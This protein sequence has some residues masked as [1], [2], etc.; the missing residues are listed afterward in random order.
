MDNF[1]I[2]DALEACG[3]ELRGSA[4]LKAGLREIVIDSRLIKPGD[5][6]VAYRGEKVDGHDY[7]SAALDRGAACCLAERVP[8]GEGR[9]LILVPDVQSALEKIA[10]AY[11][12]RFSIPLIGV[13]GSVG[14]T[15]TKEMLH[16]VLSRRFNTLKTEGNLN[17]QIGVPMTLSRL[18]GRHEAAV[19][20]LGISG[21]GEMSVLA[22]MARPNIAVFTRIAHAHLE[23]LHD[24]DGVF[25]AKTELL[26]YLPP[27]GLVIV[28]GDDEKLRAVKCPQRVITFGLGE[29]CD[30]RAEKVEVD[31]AGCTSCEIV[32]GE[33]RLTARIPAYGR[34]MIY[35]ALAS[36][37]AGFALGLEAEEIAEGIAAYHT[38]GRRGVVCDTGYITLIDDCY[39]A[40]PDSMYCAIDSLMTLPGRHVCVFSDMREQGET[41]SELHR[42]VGLY[43]LEKGVDFVAAYGPMSRCLTA[44]MGDKARHFETREELISHLPALIER[45]DN[46]LV[47]A[48]LG[49]H[50]EPVAEALKKLGE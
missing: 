22:A 3:G 13:T 48:S 43:A 46:V 32:C 27:D 15:T 26:A 10:A 24:L 4:A 47:K 21:F 38:V 16:A 23:F 50:L 31:S 41:S 5:L 45:G 6:F 8:E 12:A 14:K 25:K 35:A 2:N 20:E 36:A 17:N 42:A 39:N 9:G 34:H 29:D 40:N 18:E 30:V 11:R 1:T 33:A 44:A 37:A 7:I 19:V 49:M 28:N